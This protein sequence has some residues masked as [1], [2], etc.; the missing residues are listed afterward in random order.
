M[1]NS[2]NDMNEL[3]SLLMIESL[4]TPVLTPNRLI[5]EHMMCI[6]IL[7]A[8]VGTEIGAHFILTLV[9]KFDKMIQ[10]PQ[11]VENKELDNLVLMISNLYNF[12]VL[13]K[14]KMKYSSILLYSNI[15][16]RYLVLN[17]SIK[18]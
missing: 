16:I 7:H 4:V 11:E 17:L 2:R 13:I 9:Q 5:T 8:N 14:K 1:C 18:F 3:L 15:F 6:A 12:K 10:K